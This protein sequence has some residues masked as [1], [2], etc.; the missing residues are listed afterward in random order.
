MDTVI[1][2]APYHYV[3]ILNNNTNVTRVVVGPTTLTRQEHE[4]LVAGPEPMVMVPPRHYC[5]VANPVKRNDADGEVA[6]DTNG[7]AVVRWGDEEIRFEQEPFP[8]YPGERLSGRVTPLQVVAPNTAFRLRAL[9][10]FVDETATVAVPQAAPAPEETPAATAAAAAAAEDDDEQ[11]EDTKEEEEEAKDKEEEEKKEEEKEEKEEEE[12]P[13]G[14]QRHAGDEWLFRGPGT[15][16]PRVEVQVVSV[17]KATIV[18][19]RQALRLRA[20]CGMVSRDGVERKAG[21]EWL[22]REPGAYLPD[23]DEEVKGVVEAQVLTPAKALRMRAVR[24]F[25]DVGGVKRRAGE[26]WLVTSEMEDMHLTDV[27]ETL[28]GEISVTVLSKRQ[29]AVVV[30]PVDAHGVPQLGKRELRRGECTFFLQPGETLENGIQGVYVLGAEEALLLRAKEDF[31][32][33][34]TKT[35]HK[36]GDRWMVYGP[37]DFI[38]EVQV[39]V[40]ERRHSI[41]LDTNEGVYVRDIT[42]GHVRSEMGK[43][44]MLKPNEE[45]WAKELPPIVEELVG[46]D[47]SLPARAARDKTRVVSYHLPHNSVV[48]VYDYKEKRARVVF[49]PQLVSLGPDEQFT[50]LSLSGG[51]PKAPHRI[52]TLAMRLG[53]DFMT[54]VITVETSDHARLSLKLSYNWF[55]DVA[56]RERDGPKLFAV[57]DFIGDCCKAIAAR[58]RGAVAATPF[59]VFHKTSADLIRRA[60]FGTADSDRYVFAANNLV[61]LG[62]DIQSV[63]PVDQRTRDSLQQSVQ[64]AIELTTKSQEACARHVAE[65]LEQEAKGRLDRQKLLDEAEAEKARKLLLSLQAQSTAIETTGQ[66]T[67]DARAHAESAQIQGEAAVKQADLE[68]QARRIRADAELQT[69]KE[70]QA[71]E[72]IYQKAADELEV[73]RARQLAEIEADKFRKLVRAIG[74]ETLKAM[75]QA[76]PEMQAKLL[77]GLGLKSVM[78]TDGNSPINLF[79]TANGLISKP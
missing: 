8:L 1:R 22:V 54:D 30:N 44:Y 21:E 13:K 29:Y 76:G 23:V 5:L 57:P 15:Y 40:V 36:P 42:S 67:A 78:I 69:I 60:V 55:F 4:K 53:P 43:S 77:G 32:D 74:P 79:T 71:Q 66:A 10:D 48:Q 63:E 49:G 34:A 62:V 70:R 50:V 11:E 14:V 12:K 75:A 17:E 46:R 9:R 16:I 31:V 24:S 38:P 35:A 3:H 59:E 72:L 27:Y 52:K 33:P 7:Q 37:C 28:V 68:A 73:A 26:E 51:K 2:I 25:T 20:R 45:L 18:R 65:R 61:I 19:P 64:L 58:V 39:E 47:M 41:A 6:V 56:D